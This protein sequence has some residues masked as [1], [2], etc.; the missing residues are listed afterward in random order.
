VVSSPIPEAPPVTMARF[1]LRSTPSL[2]SSAVDLAVNEVAI[3]GIGAVLKVGFLP[4]HG[5]PTTPENCHG[6]PT[7]AW[8]R[9]GC[10]GDTFITG[11]DTDEN[12]LLRAHRLDFRPP[13]QIV[14]ADW[15]G[16]FA[17]VAAGIGIALVPQLVTVALPAG[18]TVLKLRDEQAPYRRVVAV[19]DA[20][21]EPSELTRKFIRLAKRA[22]RQGVL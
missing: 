16:K 3:L 21:R 20:R 9:G 8:L 14:V 13:S 22:A 18:V 7:V 17:C 10:I 1:P 12:E 6:C 19:T 11:S 15:I 2:T 5:D 4:G